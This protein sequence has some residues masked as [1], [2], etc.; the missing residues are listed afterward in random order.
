MTKLFESK[1]QKIVF[2]LFFTDLFKECSDFA[3]KG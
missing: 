3:S 1:V 2:R